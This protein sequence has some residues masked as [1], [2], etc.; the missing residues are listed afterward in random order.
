VHCADDIIERYPALAFATI[1]ALGAVTYAGISVL[2]RGRVD[3]VET[4]LFAA[5]FGVIYV[6]VAAYSDAIE[7]RFGVG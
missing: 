6:G 1:V 7:E 5:I 4:G 2:T 3:A